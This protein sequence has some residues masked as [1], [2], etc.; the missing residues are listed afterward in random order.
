MSNR[1]LKATVF[2][3]SNHLHS[4]QFAALN[5]ELPGDTLSGISMPCSGN[6]DLAYLVKAFETGADGVVIERCKS[7][8]CRH[9]EGTLRAQK[10]AQ[11]VEA[12]LEEI[13]MEVGRMA[14]LECGEG[15]TN[16]VIDEIKAF[17]NELRKLPPMPAPTAP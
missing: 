15:G 17:M 11:A 14:V 6:V 13:G 1:A 4:E 3:C 7:N 16:Q 12:L 10:R 2:Y 9:F 8:E 5:A